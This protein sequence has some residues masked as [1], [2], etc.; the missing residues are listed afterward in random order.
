MKT[1]LLLLTA[2]MLGATVAARAQA[3]ST[4]DT[5]MILENEALKVTVTPVGARIVGR[6]DKARQRENAKVLPYYGGM[7]IVRFG[8]ALN[9]DDNKSRYDLEL[10]RLPDGSQKLVATAKFTPTD[11]K[12]G[13][14]TVAKEFVL[15]PGS[16][17]LRLSVEI[18]N[19]GADEIGIIPWIQHLL[20]RGTKEQ[21]E[22]TFMTERG[23]VLKVSGRASGPDAH[24][25]PAGNWTSRVTLP[26][27]DAANTIATL[28]RP[29][30]MFTCQFHQRFEVFDVRL[31]EVR[32]R[33]QK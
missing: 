10:S 12:P 29:E 3:P 11:D 18:R 15:A 32:R 14:G 19:E 33:L 27:E 16:G 24:Y 7:N 22:E 5:P 13:T 17:C 25:F 2:A 8:A 26:L 4:P 9:L 1:S 30:D 6:W 28:T 31:N 23:A 21:P 20:L